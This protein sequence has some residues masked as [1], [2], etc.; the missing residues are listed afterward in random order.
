M[1][2]FQISMYWNR[3]ISIVDEGTVVLKRTAFSRNVTEADDFSNALFNV[4]GEML[5]QPS[6]GEAAFLGVMSTEIKEFIKRYPI[7]TLRSGDVLISNDPWLGASQL[8]DYTMVTP[9]FF[10]RKLVGFSGCCAH[11]ADVGGRVLSSDSTDIHEEGFIIPPSFLYRRGRAND[12]LFRFVRANVR[13]PDIVIGD[14]M[15]QVSSNELV[16]KRVLVFLEEMGLDDLEELGDQI[17]IRSDEAVKSVIEK[18]PEGTYIGQIEAD[19][20]EDPIV[21][22]TKIDVT[23]GEIVVDF[24]GTSMQST[25]GINVTFNWTYADTV[26][27]LL[28]AFRPDSP[29]NAGS[30]KRFRVSAPPGCILNAQY[31]A[32]VGA[33]VLVA[34]HIQ[35]AVFRALQDVMTDSILADSAAPTWVPVLSGINQ[36]GQRFVE[37][38]IVHG[39]IGARPHK[40]GIVIAY[41][42][43][44]PTT[45]IEIFENEKPILVEK[46]EFVIDTAGAGRYRGGHGQVF[47]FKVQGEHEVRLA[48]RADRT[49]HPPLGFEGGSSGSCG[50]AVLNRS[51][52]LHPKRT[53]FLKPGD[54]VTLQTPGGG[55][56]YCASE[57]HLEAIERDIDD[58]VLSIGKARE[59]Y[60]Y[61]GGNND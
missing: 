8:N 18:L 31:P 22:Q 46:K 52:N 41:P 60:G 9:I 42:D 7:E 2:P 23:P 32:A 27:A 33:R 50:V 56:F 61:L 21:I 34:H 43:H 11:S 14:F 49:E 6:Q 54:H 28:C 47:E 30:L 5:V 36:Y 26:H 59:S 25:R 58:E 53:I 40:D 4:H 37:I 35:G 16:K 48:M 44:P 51:Q 55:G 57:R 13:V 38:L 39:G 20:D 15:A 19:G 17:L 24:T 12:E 29:I 3:L 45:A 10:R 1:D